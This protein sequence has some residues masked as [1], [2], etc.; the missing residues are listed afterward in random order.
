[1]NTTDREQLKKLSEENGLNKDHFFKSP[2]GW[3]IITRNG[4]ERIQSHRGIKVTYDMVHLSDDLKRVVVKATGEMA[5]KGTLPVTV[6]TYGESSPENTK[7]KYPVAMAEKRALSRVVLKL[8]GFYEA[9]VYGQDEADEF[10]KG[11]PLD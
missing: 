8:T 4:I 9:G 7:Q 1:M 6:E 11:E 3:V 5:G 2:Q 10:R